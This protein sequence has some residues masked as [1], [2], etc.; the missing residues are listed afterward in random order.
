VR[1]KTSSTGGRF[2]SVLPIG[3]AFCSLAATI[4]AT[5]WVAV[6]HMAEARARADA[7]ARHVAAQLRVGVVQAVEPLQRI[8]AWW[9]LQGRPLEPEDWANDAQL[10]MSEKVGLQKIV[11]LDWK[12][13]RTWTVRP[14]SLPNM[15]RRAVPDPILDAVVG[16][17]RHT[18]TTALSQAFDVEGKPYFYA[19][20]PIR[21]DGRLIAYI[22]GMYDAADFI[23]SCA[24]SSR[25][26]SG[27]PSSRMAAPFTSRK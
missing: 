5:Q 3:V 8:A 26:S 21:K 6:Q 10:F 20:A 14:G 11:W 9:L 2:V 13:A 17:A 1:T 15:D 19:C 4:C 24:I 7:E 25:M 23:H 18:T 27:S 12:G 22:A 16:E